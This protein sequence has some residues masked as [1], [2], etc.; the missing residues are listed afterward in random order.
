[1]KKCWFPLLGALL[2][3]LWACSAPR[4]GAGNPQPNAGRDK[5]A[6]RYEPMDTLRWTTPANPKPPIKNT[7]GTPGANTGSTGA[8]AGNTYR[9]AFVLPFLGN[10]F[11]D[12][13]VPEKSRLALQFYAGARLAL[14]EVSKNG[15]INLVV[16]VLD[17]QTSDAEF[18]AV[19]AD[20]QLAKAD[21]IVGPVRSSH[22]QAAAEWAKKN[23]KIL[24]SPETPNS[25]LTQNNPDFIQCNPS[26]R[27][28][29]IGIAQYATQQYPNATFTLLCK[30]KEAD[31][32]PY[33]QD[34]LSSAGKK[35]FGE[36]I[37]PDEATN[38]D[39][40]D[41][42]QA[43]KPGKTAVFILPMWSSQ[44]FVMA[45]LRK[46]K[47]VKGNQQVVV[48]GMPQWKNF[49][50]IEPDYLNNLNV[51]I[52]SAAY[53]DPANLDVKAY[54]Q[55]FYDAT[56]TIPDEDGFNGYQI[57]SWLSEQLYRHG[58]SFPKKIFGEENRGLS[59]RFNFFKTNAPADSNVT[60]WDYTEN[61]F[62]FILKFDKFGFVPVQNQ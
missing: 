47:A 4:P 41:L 6:Q 44:D 58:L 43:F 16:D 22:V 35:P 19:L 18:Q 3:L 52:S 60:T 21:V 56:G 14:E 50:S 10:Q 29:C 2:C 59:A 31:R 17:S 1:M 23:R 13:S 25:G 61:G 37:V 53:I 26:L 11:D 42:K 55:R 30:Q 15:R 38:L 33:F 24:I 45:F 28:H 54:M 48:F 40:T 5:P 62:V 46:L 51:H 34:Y 20:R 12:V 27:A 7:P 36:I 8:G 49:D 39:K 9:I 57:T 32:L